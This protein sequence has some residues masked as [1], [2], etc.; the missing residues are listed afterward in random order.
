MSWSPC[1]LGFWFCHLLIWASFQIRWLP[2]LRFPGLAPLGPKH[3]FLAKARIS[4]APTAVL[5]HMV[6]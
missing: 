3:G 4:V 5:L 2:G 1:S 6:Q